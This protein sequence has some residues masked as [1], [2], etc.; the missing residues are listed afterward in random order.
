MDEAVVGDHVGHREHP[1]VALLGQRVRAHPGQHPVR[2]DEPLVHAVHATGQPPDAIQVQ[3]RHGGT[4]KHAGRTARRDQ[5]AHRPGAQ[6]DVGV[7]IDAGKGPAGTV[8]QAQRVR[9]APHRCLDHPRTRL[10]G[11]RGGAI[12]AGVGHHDDVELTGDGPVEQ[13][14]QVAGDDRLLVVRRNH[15]ADHR[16]H[17][18]RIGTDRRPRLR[19]HP[20]RLPSPPETIAAAVTGPVQNPTHS[21]RDVERDA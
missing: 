20:N 4:G 19:A 7:Q 17:G 2:R 5:C 13:P 11:E 3:L 6:L 8:A 16:Y 15:D 9:L 21:A 14:A 12:G 18:A 10:A 1:G